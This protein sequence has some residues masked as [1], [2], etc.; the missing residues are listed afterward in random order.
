MQ[1]KTYKSKEAVNK[2]W[3]CMVSAAEKLLAALED[4]GVPEEYVLIKSSGRG[5]HFH[6][7]CEGFR[8][9]IQYKQALKTIMHISRSHNKHQTIT[10]KSYSMGI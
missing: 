6:I 8:D 5:L 10:S 2:E 4:F 7:F 9:D 3:K 1:A